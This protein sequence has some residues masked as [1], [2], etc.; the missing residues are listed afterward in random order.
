[1]SGGEITGS[2]GGEMS[3]GEVSGSRDLH[4]FSSEGDKICVRIILVCINEVLLYN[5]TKI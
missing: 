3:G 4:V 5:N 1:M 2:F